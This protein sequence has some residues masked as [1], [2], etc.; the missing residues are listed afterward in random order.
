M[1]ASTLVLALSPSCRFLVL[2]FVFLLLPLPVLSSSPKHTDT[3][4]RAR[5]KAQGRMETWHRAPVC[6]GCDR[7]PGDAK[8]GRSKSCIT[9]HE[10]YASSAGVGLGAGW[11]WGGGGEGRELR[12]RVWR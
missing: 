9:S 2:V 5:Y 11:R 1:H 12:Q 6:G 3:D 10:V 7:R 4:T 8:D